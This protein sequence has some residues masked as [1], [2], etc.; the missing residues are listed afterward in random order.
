[1]LKRR[2]AVVKSLGAMRQ[3]LAHLPPCLEAEAKNALEAMNKLIES[4]DRQIQ[5]ATSAKAEIGE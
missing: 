1:M 3:S 2:A 4:I 5:Q